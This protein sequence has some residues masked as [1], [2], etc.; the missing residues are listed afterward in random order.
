MKVV[1]PIFSKKLQELRKQKD[2]NQTVLGKQVNLGWKT[3][4]I[5]AVNQF[6]IRK[7]HTI[8]GVPFP[9]SINNTKGEFYASLI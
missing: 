9:L 6:G 2:M 1:N 3:H 8:S 5:F 4:K 7:R